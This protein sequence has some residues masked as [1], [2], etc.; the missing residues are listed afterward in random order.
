MSDNAKQNADWIR[1]YDNLL[2]IV[3]TIFATAIGGLLVYVHSNFDV[4]LA[5]FGMLITPVAVYFAASFRLLRSEFLLNQDNKSWRLPQWPAYVTI[6][7]G[8]EFLWDYLLLSHKNYSIDPL[9]WVGIVIP[10]IFILCL[11]YLGWN[12][13]NNDTKS[14]SDNTE[15]TVTED[16]KSNK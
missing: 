8:L 13:R 14:M 3:T 15:N 2:W 10:W 6:F 12:L 7:M 16:K 1:H 5:I 9:S 11:L 4:I